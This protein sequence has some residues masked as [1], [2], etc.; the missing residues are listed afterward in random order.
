V[1]TKWTPGPWKWVYDAKGP[2]WR[3]R[4]VS[5]IETSECPAFDGLDPII[6]DG[7]AGGEYNMTI[8]PAT[9]PAAPLLA[10]APDL[11]AVLVTI[12]RS[13]SHGTP[14]GGETCTMRE[15]IRAAL[16]K[17]RGEQA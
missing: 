8:D 14:K 12:E 3:L 10:A 6:D 9:S 11:Y 4:S 2:V 5:A 1:S 17:A 15:M 13:I 16:A 7:S